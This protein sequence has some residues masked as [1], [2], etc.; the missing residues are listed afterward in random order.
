MYLFLRCFPKTDSV[1]VDCCCCCTEEKLCCRAVKR[2]GQSVR[3]F[4]LRCFCVHELD[5][6]LDVPHA[7]YV[8]KRALRFAE[9][10]R[11]HETKYVAPH[12]PEA[13]LPLHMKEVAKCQWRTARDF[14]AIQM[15]QVLHQFDYHLR[16]F[17]DRKFLT[18]KVNVLNARQKP[19]PTPPAALTDMD[20]ATLLQR[21]RIEVTTAAQ[22]LAWCVVFTV[23]ELEKLRR[24]FI[25]A[26]QLNCLEEI[27]FPFEE[28]FGTRGRAICCT[29]RGGY[30]LGFPFFLRADAA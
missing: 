4:L 11:G 21:N 18:D 27:P 7:Y 30:D 5:G 20:I 17:T 13:Q 8:V 9:Q 6:E 23:L 16:W 3:S 1:G 25:T 26:P 24:R 12:S 29:H 10:G 19:L 15:P 2:E 14:V 22:V 28:D